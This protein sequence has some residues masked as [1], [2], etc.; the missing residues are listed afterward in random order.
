MERYYV[1]QFDIETF[2]VADN[3]T[4]RE[5]CVC[6]SFDQNEDA[7]NRAEKIA[8]ALNYITADPR[9]VYDASLKCE[10]LFFQQDE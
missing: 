2:I 6:G 3:A 7:E 10:E 9:D 5:V 1:Y 8:A 4:N